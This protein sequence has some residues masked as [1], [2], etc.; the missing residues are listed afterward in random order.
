MRVEWY[1]GDMRAS[2]PGG[3]ASCAN[4]WHMGAHVWCVCAPPLSPLAFLKNCE[5]ADHPY[6]LVPVGNKVL[7]QTPN[8]WRGCSQF[9]SACI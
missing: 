4:Y 6:R 9:G 8:N 7:E 1:V 5:E 2:E 3:L